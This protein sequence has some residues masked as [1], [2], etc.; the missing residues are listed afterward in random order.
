MNIGNYLTQISIPDDVPFLKTKLLDVNMRL[1]RSNDRYKH[2]VTKC[3]EL[4]EFCALQK[5]D[6]Y[7]QPYGCSGANVGIP[8]NI[9]GVV[10]N[11]GKASTSVQIFL[12]PKILRTG[13]F[14][15]PTETNCGSLRLPKAVKVSRWQFVTVEWY[16]LQG[17][18]H[19][20]QFQPRTGS[21]TLQHEIDHNN[22][23]LITDRQTT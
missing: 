17:E 14:K 9:V 23:I 1:M 18:I 3:C 21:F 16:D 7:S 10:K 19:V 22:G 20:E 11:R 5:F 2:I 12:N 6:D 4:I 8:F 15:I 13:K